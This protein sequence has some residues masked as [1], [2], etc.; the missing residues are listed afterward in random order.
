MWLFAPDR[1]MVVTDFAMSWR[2]GL[3][4]EPGI[5]PQIAALKEKRSFPDEIDG[6]VVRRRDDAARTGRAFD[7]LNSLTDPTFQRR[8][9]D[10]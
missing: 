7:P 8:S 2:A 10:A 9:T 5:R 4:T 1:R 6:D 3:V